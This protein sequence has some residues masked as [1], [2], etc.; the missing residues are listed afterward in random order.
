MQNVDATTKTPEEIEDSMGDTD[1]S[2][3]DSGIPAN[4]DET[5]G[6]VPDDASGTMDSGGAF[7]NTGT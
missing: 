7:A 2:D 1:E 4:L 6:A 5:P 3:K